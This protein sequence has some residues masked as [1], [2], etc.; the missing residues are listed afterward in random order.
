MQFALVLRSAYIDAPRRKLSTDHFSLRCDFTTGSTVVRVGSC[1][2][3]KIKSENSFRFSPIA[4]GLL[5]AISP[6]S[7]SFH[8]GQEHL[9]HT[10][11]NASGAPVL[12]NRL[13]SMTVTKVKEVVDAKFLQ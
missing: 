13:I 4:M 6:S 10:A 3:I 12:D 2:N 1:V 7:R 11:H 5:Q 8:R 9:A